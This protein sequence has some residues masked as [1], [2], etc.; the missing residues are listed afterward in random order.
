M[1]PKPHTSANAR[2]KHSASTFIVSVRVPSM[3]NI[4][5]CMGRKT[6]PPV[7]T[8]FSCRSSFPQA[9]KEALLF[10]FLE[11]AGID[12]LLRTKIRRSGIGFS[13]LVQDGFQGFGRGPRDLRDV[14]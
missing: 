4:T 3:S 8:E 14:L 7:R 6:P 9:L 13:H 1:S 2:T 12:K 11:K 10:Q 5:R